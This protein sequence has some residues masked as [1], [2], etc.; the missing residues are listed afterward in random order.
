AAA[1]KLVHDINAGTSTIATQV[2]A[3][4][5]LPPALVALAD[6]I[7]KNAGTSVFDLFKAVISPAIAYRNGFA[8]KTT[9][10]DAAR[11]QRVFKT[12][13]SGNGEIAFDLPSLQ[14]DAYLTDM[15]TGIV[16]GHNA[17][18][19]NERDLFHGH[20]VPSEANRDVA[21]IFHAKEYPDEEF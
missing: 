1:D 15:F 16:A 18:V 17:T 7:K 9:N 12:M 10:T 20:I 5:P 2:H 19:I 8:M 11:Q 13:A 4:Q 3:C 14:L 21:I 6:A